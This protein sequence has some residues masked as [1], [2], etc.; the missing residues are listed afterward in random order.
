MDENV[1][2]ILAGTVIIVLALQKLLVSKNSSFSATEWPAGPT[3]LPIIG[4]LHQLGGDLFHVVLAKLGKVHGD[5]FTIWIGSWNPVIIVSDINSA[6]EVLVTKSSDYS[7]RSVPDYLKI[8]SAGGESIADS[9]SGPFWHSLRKGLQNFALNPLNVMSQSHLQERDMQNLII[10]M[11]EDASRE[12]GIIKPFDYVRKEAVRLLSRIVF[13]QDFSNEDFVAAMSDTVH[14]LVRTGGFASLADAFKIGEYLPSHKKFINDLNDVSE[15]AANLILPYIEQKAPTNTYLHFLTSQD[16]SEVIIVS[17]ILELYGLAAD[18]TAATIVW[19]LKFLVRQQEIQEKLY[20]EIRDVT[21]GTRPVKIADLK[22]M[23]YL[24][25]LVKETVRMK[26]IGPMAIPHKATKN[27]SLMGKKI[28][29]GTQVMV[30]IYAIH[31][32]SDVFPEPYKFMPERFLKDVNSDASLGDREKMESSL[33][34]FGAGMRVCAGMDIAK[35]I[36][37]FGIA[38]LVNEFKW[39]SVYDGKLPDLTED[40]SFILLIKN[41]LEARITPRVD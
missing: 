21:G 38:S 18:S 4:N 13:G 27:T 37:S 19:A 22:K 2:C 16:H 15:R 33:L 14:N 26:P 36:V 32:N 8:V 7:A 34:A 41:P 17:A 31:H 30:N 25:A 9:D 20:R 35:L 39:D 10:S 6:R 23:P 28:D 1:M 11:R 5:V 12:N 3:A 24:Q 29:K 40:I